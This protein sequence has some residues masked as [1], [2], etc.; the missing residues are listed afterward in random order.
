MTTPPRPARK[1]PVILRG[2]PGLE[3]PRQRPRP[4]KR[5]AEPVRTGP[6]R[7]VAFHKPYGVLCQ[8]T[9]DQPGQK[10]LAD[11][12]L[13]PGLYPVGRL[14]QDSEGL[15]LLSNNG[16]LIQ[17]LLEPRFGHPRTYLAQV[18][19]IPTE[20]ALQALRDGVTIRINKQDHHTLPARAV[21]DPAEPDLPPRDPP[22]R[23]RAAIPTA[24]LRLTLTEGKN[25]QVRRMTAAVGFPTLRLIRVAIGA[26]P[27]GTLAPG[28][29]RD[30]TPEEIGL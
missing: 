29:W 23:Y 30:V 15:L 1:R 28:Q 5:P 4:P 18:E 26:L 10:T 17:H 6:S 11:F 27:L 16:R 13:P 20:Q 9:P 7:T 8:F 24:W 12:D 14:D 19:N 2:L 3:A 21:L 22:V 25:R